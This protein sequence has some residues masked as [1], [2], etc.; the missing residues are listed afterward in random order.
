MINRIEHRTNPTVVS[1][2]A[3]LASQRSLLEVK[4]FDT[5]QP[6]FHHI[7]SDEQKVQLGEVISLATALPRSAERSGQRD[8]S[9][10]T[11]MQ[12]NMTDFAKQLL[13]HQLPYAER[14]QRVVDKSAHVHADVLVLSDYSPLLYERVER[15]HY[16]PEGDVIDPDGELRQKLVFFRMKGH[17][18]YLGGSDEASFGLYTNN[19]AA[20][21]PFWEYN[22]HD[23]SV[24][25]L[26]PH[27]AM[28]PYE[29]Q[30]RPERMTDE[31]LGYELVKRVSLLLSQVDR[32]E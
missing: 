13:Q 29:L 14:E 18:G 25:D 1:D 32:L 22:A 6:R 5:A 20:Q 12:R 2:E 3:L 24:S 10:Y 21:P 28:Y 4:D 31:A 30:A 8:D 9:F 27:N 19:L 16:T 17:S 7:F 23:G 26:L 15:R 11:A